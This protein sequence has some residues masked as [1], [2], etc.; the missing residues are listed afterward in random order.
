VLH[1]AYSWPNDPEVF[2]GD[3]PVYRII[4]G[5]GGTGPAPITPAQPGILTCSDLPA[6]YHY[7]D[8]RTNCG[9]PVNNQG[10]VFGAGVVQNQGP[11]QWQS[12]GHDWPCNLDERGAG[13][14]GVVCRWNPPPAGNCSPPVT[15]DKYVTNS[16]CGRV[17]SGTS[18][19]SGSI[20][21][22][23]GDPLFV[24]VAIP[25]VLKKVSLPAS[26]SGCVPAQGVGAWSLVASQAV[27]TNEGIVAWYKGTANTSLACNITV[28]MANKNPAELK[29]YDVPK[30]NGTVE[31]MSSDSGDF[32][33]GPP[34][35]SVTAGI[36]TTAYS[37]DLQL[38]ALL[39]VDQQPTPITYW[40]N[41]LTNGKNQLSCLDNNT[42]CPKDD[43]TDYLPGNGPFSGNSDVGHKAVAPGTHYFHRDAFNI[44]QFSWGGLAIYLELNP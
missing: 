10:A 29:V 6:N 1:G 27:H 3:A 12:N 26:V 7:S 4:F 16:A 31:A 41:W 30:F 34:F 36:A 18:L 22:N 19:V 40:T 11:Q 9:I 32:N 35:P 38:G 42:N 5:P 20:T 24:E 17:D 25:K 39:M 33:G 8:N 44:G 37:N 2:G 43:G 28:T 21:P 23:S 13:D 14:N 15:D